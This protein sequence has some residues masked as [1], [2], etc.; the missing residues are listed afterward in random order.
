M[1]AFTD[2]AISDA[3]YNPQSGWADFLERY[4]QT[5]GAFVGLM[6]GSVLVRLATPTKGVKSILSVIGLVVL[7]F[8]M[9][10][11]FMAD[12]TGLQAH[13]DPNPAL[14]LGGA[15]A[16]VV[17]AQLVLRLIARERLEGFRPAAKVALALPLVAGVLTVWLIK[18]PWGRWTYR[19]FLEA[20]DPSLFTPWFIPQG[21][22][23]HHSFISGHTAFSFSLL[24][25]ALLF[26][27]SKTA[28]KTALAVALAWG[29]LGRRADR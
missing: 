11:S 29:V 24:S 1:F 20:G 7:T 5:T 27:K 21:N 2:E 4:G 8:L 22:N 26:V 13:K 23:G 28:F 9:A 10:L 18:I 12:A 15:V 14:I 25:A 16:I 3:L 17:V 6:G 19:D